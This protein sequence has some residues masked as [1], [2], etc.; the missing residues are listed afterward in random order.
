MEFMS[1]S[2]GHGSY[3]SHYKTRSHGRGVVVGS[4][5]HVRTIEGLG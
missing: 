2:S 1:A 4:V 5:E 3:G